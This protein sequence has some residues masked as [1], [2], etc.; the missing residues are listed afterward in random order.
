MIEIFDN[1]LPEHEYECIRAY[2][3]GDNDGGAIHNSCAWTYYP[4]ITLKNDGHFQ[5]VQLVFSQHTVLSPAYDL[6][7]PIIN[8][9]KMCA[10]ARIKANCVIKTHELKVFTNAFH[11]DYPPESNIIT[12]IYYINTNDGHTLFE[13][14]QKCESVANRFCMFPSGMKHTGTTCSDMDRRILINFNFTTYDKHF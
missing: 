10:I 12:G 3:E 13:D 8:K 5:F 11:D 14:G 9:E 1:Y 4:G 2:F 7:A 6:L